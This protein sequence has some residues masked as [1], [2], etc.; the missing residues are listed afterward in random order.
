MGEPQKLGSL[1]LRCSLISGCLQPMPSLFYCPVL[2]LPCKF[3]PSP[4]LSPPYAS[5][6]VPWSA[7][8]VPLFSSLGPVP[9]P[10]PPYDGVIIA[11]LACPTLPLELR[12]K[13]NAVGIEK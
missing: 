10:A 11:G 7:A 9:T 8:S 4:Q 6:D 13:D 12:V 2:F 5:C 1:L 3:P